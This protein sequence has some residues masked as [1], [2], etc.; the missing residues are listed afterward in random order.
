MSPFEPGTGGIDEDVA[1]TLNRLYRLVRD[2]SRLE[3][4]GLDNVPDGKALLV[5]NHTGWA[6]WDFANLY[7]TV[8]DD[9]ER[10]LYTAVHPNW[11]RLDRLSDIARRAGMYEAGVTESV[12]ILDQDD[13]VLFFPEGERGNFKPFTQR[14]QLQEFQ[15]GFARVASASMAP[16]VPVVIV[17]GE[18]AHPTLTRLEFTKDLIGVGLPVPATLLPLPVKW[19]IKF[20]PPIYPDK[21][22]TSEAA[23]RDVVEDIRRDIEALMQREV[24]RAVD[25]RGH[26][27]L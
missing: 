17:G 6:G 1:E 7:V 15:A 11:F 22:M 9:L 12:R 10:D 24:Q 21:Y 2:Y 3:V 8:R 16:V 19:R 23:D 5:A 4:D 20:L 25:E 18:E 13:L 26:P 27:F 14:Y